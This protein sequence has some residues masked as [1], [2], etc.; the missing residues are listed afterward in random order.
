TFKE[1]VAD[2]RNSRVFDVVTELRSY[3]AQV[4]VYDPVADPAEAAREYGIQLESW[5]QLPR[6]NAIIAAVAHRRLACL[7]PEQIAQKLYPGGVFVD[8]KS[9]FA[10][11]DLTRLGARVWRL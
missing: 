2:L 9:A 8:I 7:P 1:D 3:G 5:E 10:A 11:A 6:S 4:H